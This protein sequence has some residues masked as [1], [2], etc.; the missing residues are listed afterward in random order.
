MDGEM[1][2]LAN[3]STMRDKFSASGEIINEEL[4]CLSTRQPIY[5]YKKTDVWCITYRYSKKLEDD[6]KHLSENVDGFVKDDK[7]PETIL[8]DWDENIVIVIRLIL[9]KCL[10]S[11][12]FDLMKVLLREKHVTFNVN[13]TITDLKTSMNILIH[14]FLRG[15]LLWNQMWK[16]MKFF[17]KQ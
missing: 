5:I 16:N 13:Y 2:R 3:P 4:R 10:R 9:L 17:L 12:A 1:K 7:T 14:E 8:T 6:E 11:Y 15:Y